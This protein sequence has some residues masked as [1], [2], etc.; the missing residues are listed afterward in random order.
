LITRIAGWSATSF[1]AFAR[2]IAQAAFAERDDARKTGGD[3][4]PTMLTGTGNY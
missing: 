3:R 1:G 2:R 4:P